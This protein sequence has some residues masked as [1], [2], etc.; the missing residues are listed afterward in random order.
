MACLPSTPA[1]PARP[2]ARRAGTAGLIA[3]LLG[4]GS[5]APLAEPASGLP[6]DESSGPRP[7]RVLLYAGPGPVSAGRHQVLPVPGAAAGEGGVLVDGTPVAAPWRLAGPVAL[8]G[9]RY[10][11]SVE[12]SRGPEGLQVINRVPLE[13]YVAGTVAREVYPGWHPA[14]LRAQA[15]VAR[16]YALYRMARRRNA[17][18]D[19]VSG[20]RSQV[21]GG[22]DAE[23][24]STVR[25]VRATRGEHLAYEGRPILAAYHACAGGRTASAEEV[26]GGQVPYLVSQAVEGEEDAPSTYWRIPVS[27]ATLGR[28]LAGAGHAVGT[29]QRVRVSAR[30]PSGRV[31]RV[32]IE[33]SSGEAE[34]TGRTLRGEGGALPSTLFEVRESEGGFVFVGSGS[35]HGVGMS[36]WGARAM[37][38]RGAGYEEILAR[39]YPGTTLRRG[40]G[41]AEAR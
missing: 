30:S 27:T 36:Q 20:A 38:R 15:V 2:S 39:F 37:A 29:P 28:V 33:G 9:V 24:P 26:W 8:N 16:T 17:A 19:V 40:P 3:G 23:M 18:W 41:L 14:V 7:V 5:L 25:A 11:G 31:R 4:V 35:G 6:R 1:A 10:R 32:R 22:I 21:Y 13:E 34:V 12:I